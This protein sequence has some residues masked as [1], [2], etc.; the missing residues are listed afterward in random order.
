MSESARVN[1]TC[2]SAPYEGL[3]SAVIAGIAGAAVV[4]V[5]TLTCLIFLCK[6]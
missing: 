3:A 5:I 2:V 6:R 1:G 4:A